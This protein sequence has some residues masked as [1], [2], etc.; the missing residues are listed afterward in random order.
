MS[1]LSK[2]MVIRKEI[3]WTVI[4]GLKMMK[5][6][7]L[8]AMEPDDGLLQVRQPGVKGNSFIVDRKSVV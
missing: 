1:I 5:G 2:V 4:F 3:Y 8:N 7:L 6:G